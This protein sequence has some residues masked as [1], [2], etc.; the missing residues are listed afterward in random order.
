MN[1]HFNYIQFNKST[2]A[3]HTSLVLQEQRKTNIYDAN[4]EN[5]VKYKSFGQAF[6]I[7]QNKKSINIECNYLGM[8]E[9]HRL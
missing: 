5:I 2:N 9:V 1:L 6:H 8:D 4:I 3:F 7:N